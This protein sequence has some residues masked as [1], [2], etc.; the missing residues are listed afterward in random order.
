MDECT[1]EIEAGELS[2]SQARMAQEALRS[3]V[4]LEALE[5]ARVQRVT[6]V[7]ASY[8]GGSAYAAVVTLDYTTQQVVE[9]ASASAA[10]TFP[11]IPGL[12]SF[13]EAPVILLALARL[14]RLPDVLIVDGH[15]LAHPRR[16]GI[17]CHLGV[18][19]DLPSIGCAKSLLIGE[20]ADL[21]AEAGSRAEVRQ[22]EELLGLALRTRQRV[23]PVYI[24]VGHR[25]DL[26]SAAHI[27]LACC[28]GQRLPE[29]ARLAHQ[30][31][32]SCARQG[33]AG[34]MTRQDPAQ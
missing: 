2:V 19:L 12:L 11:Y 28:R 24:S 20:A 31:A 15:G 8:A 1:A 30:M 5:E 29:P 23:K 26:E 9:W 13:R 3:R 16:F 22:G 34:V 17:A 33:E 14:E 4:R 32:N 18:L 27:V 21:E 7:D 6:G 10:I 25:V